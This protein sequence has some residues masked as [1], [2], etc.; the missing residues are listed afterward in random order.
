MVYRLYT[1]VKNE[2]V[3]LN[4]LPM[5]QNSIDICCPHGTGAH[6]LRWHH[7]FPLHTWLISRKRIYFLR[8]RNWI[9]VIHCSAHL[10]CSGKCLFFGAVSRAEIASAPLFFGT[11]EEIITRASHC[12]L[13]CHRAMRAAHSRSCVNC[14]ARQTAPRVHFLRLEKKHEYYFV[15]RQ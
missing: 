7:F 2:I 6:L 13:F 5:C 1:P 9:H 11:E 15:L 4:S 14:A 10:L 3:L 8:H 12:I